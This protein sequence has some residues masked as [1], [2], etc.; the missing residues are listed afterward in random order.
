M[1]Y[2]RLTGYRHLLGIISDELHLLNLALQ[3]LCTT[4]RNNVDSSGTFGIESNANSQHG[5][6]HH[7]AKGGDGILSQACLIFDGPGNMEEDPGSI[8]VGPN[9]TSSWLI[10]AS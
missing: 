7:E 10:A 5:R 6:V 9:M 2:P 1:L 8:L 4:R 3:I